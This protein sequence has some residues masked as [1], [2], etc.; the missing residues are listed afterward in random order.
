M[1]T[2]KPF[3]F[4]RQEE[5]V[6]IPNVEVRMPAANPTPPLRTAGPL[7]SAGRWLELS[8]SAEGR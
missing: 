7:E 4:R 8:T 5:G 1:S 2:A 3:Q 6:V